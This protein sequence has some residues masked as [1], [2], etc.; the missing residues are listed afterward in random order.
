MHMELSSLTQNQVDRLTRERSP[1]SRMETAALVAR[2]AAGNRLAPSEREI[3]FEILAVLARDIEVKVREAL[4]DHLRSCIWLPSSLA[5]AI[6]VDVEAVAV[7]FIQFTRGLRDEDLIAIIR[8]GN[9]TKQQA[10]ARR[11]HVSSIVT[12]HLIA[13]G[14][15]MVIEA[16]IANPGAEIAESALHKAMDRFGESIP[17]QEALV[18]RSYLPDG[19][20]A[21][22]VACISDTLRQ[23]LTDRHDFPAALAEDLVRHGRER[24]LMAMLPHEA[25][26][27]DFDRVISDLCSRDAVTPTLLLRALCAGN[28]AFFEAAIAAR[29]GVTAHSAHLLL[30]DPGGRGSRAIY[31]AA[32]LPND[33]FHAFRTAL[34]LAREFTTDERGEW[35]RDYAK[36]LAER[37]ADIYDDI[38]PG[39]IETVFSQITR[40]LSRPVG[41]NVLRHAFH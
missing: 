41:E 38:G 24:S 27:D 13:C 39:D 37:L 15:E 3:A 33:L 23:R 16:V 18:E 17:V 14:G 6:A 11:E 1:E 26:A 35:K 7:P 36:C 25:S 10:A 2:E 9:G 21:R 4:V 34:D 12:E 28:L 22:L 8:A 29:A 19:V 30:Y 5:R 40:R 32:R 20:L 31:K